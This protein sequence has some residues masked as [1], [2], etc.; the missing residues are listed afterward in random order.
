VNL[1]RSGFRSERDASCSQ[2]CRKLKHG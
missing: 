2:Y 1:Y